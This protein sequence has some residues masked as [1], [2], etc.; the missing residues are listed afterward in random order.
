MWLGLYLPTGYTKAAL[1]NS[2]KYQTIPNYVEIPIIGGIVDNATQAF[3]NPCIEPQNTQYV[4]Y[5][6]D[7]LKNLIAPAS[8][9]AVPF[10]IPLQTG[11][12]TLPVPVLPNRTPGVIVPVP[13]S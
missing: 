2:E 10:T 8:G 3:V 11:S 13:Q 12:Y 9:T 5:W 7:K 1:W 4:A 6:F